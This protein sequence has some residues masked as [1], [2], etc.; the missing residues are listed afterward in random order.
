MVSGE[1]SYKEISAAMM[2]KNIFLSASSVQKTAV[3][4]LLLLIAAAPSCVNKRDRID[5]K[6]LI[7]EN[8]FAAMITDIYLA[9]GV[10]SLPKIRHEFGGRDSVMNYMDIIESYGYSYEKMNNTLN[11]YFVSKPRKLVKI[12]DNVIKNMSEMESRYQNEIVAAELEMTRKRMNYSLF[13]LPSRDTSDIPVIT[14]DLITPGTFTLT[15]T[16]TV[17]PDDASFKPHFRGWSV[18]ADSSGTGKKNE[19]RLIDYIKD[20]RPH[21]YSL[22]QRLDG[23]RPLILKLDFFNH[24]SNTSDI[25]RH[26]SIEV[27]SFT[28]IHDPL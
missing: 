6:D 22:T 9:T 16:V 3:I 11:Y 14:R 17:F 1:I 13:Q 23:S 28:Y 4:L 18:D 27:Q 2:T 10:L 26:A 5:D 15:F 19:I 20:G 8:T 21:R 24:Y 12:Y 7:P 25:D